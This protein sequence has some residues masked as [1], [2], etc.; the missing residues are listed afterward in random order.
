MAT[1]EPVSGPFRGFGANPP[2]WAVECHMDLIAEKLGIDPVEIRRKNVLKENDANGIGETVT[3]IQLEDSID[4]V[5][6][7]IKWGRKPQKEVGPWR[8]GLGIALSN[9]FTTGHFPSSVTVK[10]HPDAG[11]EVRHSAVDVGQGCNTA[12]SQIAAEEFNTSIDKIKIVS[13]DTLITPP[14]HGT[15]SNRVTWHTGNALRLAC[16]DLKRRLF[17]LASVMLKMPPGNLVIHDGLIHKKGTAAVGIKVADLFAFPMRYQPQD[18]EL[19]GRGVYVSPVIGPDP[20]TGLSKRA[21]SYYSWG[22]CTVEITVNTETGQVKVLKVIQSFD[23]GQPINPL[24]CDGQSEGGVGMGVGSALFEKMI[25]E[26]GIVINPNFIDYRI[27]S[28]MEMPTENIKV[29]SAKI[30]PHPEGPFGAKGFSEGGLI[31]TPPAIANAIAD[32][33]GVRIKELPITRESILNA[34]KA[35]SKQKE[36][37]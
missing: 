2:I 28:I 13:A 32:A 20:E 35:R 25:M 31:P 36:A 37:S 33:I 14:D 27:P 26:D 17:E 15:I 18:G 7:L 3:N 16:Q 9:K 10:M 34:L 21:V 5:V 29:M 4:K 24:I 19:L 8:R 30:V 23:M 12:L 1:N 22:A 11:I 6:K